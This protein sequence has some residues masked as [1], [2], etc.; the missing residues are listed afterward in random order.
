MRNGE[1]TTINGAW[2]EQENAWVSE[3]WCL[4]GDCWLEVTMPDKGRMVIKKAETLEGPWPMCFKTPWTGPEM[5]IRIYG[6][7]KYRYVRIYL[8]D[9]PD[10]I[11]FANTNG[12]A[13]AGELNQ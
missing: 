2:S 9:T 7:T 12:Y 5:R 8:T 10:M 13:V 11:Q 1:I 4:T 3:T 6:S